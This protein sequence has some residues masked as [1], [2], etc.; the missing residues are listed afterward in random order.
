VITRET[1]GVSACV[2]P[3]RSSVVREAG[4]VFDAVDEVEMGKKTRRITRE[5]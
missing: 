3:G 2:A 1:G 5:E 4:D